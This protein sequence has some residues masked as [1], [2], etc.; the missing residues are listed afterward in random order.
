MVIYTSVSAFGNTMSKLLNHKY[1]IRDQSRTVNA[2]DAVIVRIPHG[3]MQFHHISKEDIIE[4]IHT[5]NTYI[6]AEVVVISTLP[7]N[8]N[9]VS[10]SDWEKVIGINQM[11]REIANDW[12]VN[13]RKGDIEG[14]TG[15]QWVLVQEFGMFTNQI[16][17]LNSQHIGYNVSLSYD[18]TSWERHISKAL[19][20]RFDSDRP[21]N[22]WPKSIPMVCGSSPTK[23]HTY[24]PRNK[25]S[26][27]GMHWCMEYL[28]SRL[29]AS[30]ACLLGCAAVRLM[31]KEC[32]M[33]S[34]TCRYAKKYA[35]ILLC[36][37]HQWIMNGL[38]MM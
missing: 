10:E 25:I 17:A 9:V 4:M 37:L 20:H 22:K 13:R 18:E 24:C 3:W 29:S 1:S 21:S 35:M 16:M 30:I 19:L 11:I 28:G 36:Q 6:G 31:A 5:S 12:N 8:N 23:N 2:F 38:T 15:P 26:P 7:L 14:T 32:M 27:D 33:I 34:R